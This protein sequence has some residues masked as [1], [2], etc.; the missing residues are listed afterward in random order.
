MSRSQFATVGHIVKAHGLHGEVSFAPAKGLSV[1]SLQGLE[2]WITP[3][4]DAGAKTR[5]RSLRQGPKGPLVGLEGFDT[6]EQAATLTGR[7]LLALV[8]ALPQE[9]LDETVDPVGAS[10]VD[11]TRGDL[12]V[13]TG[14]IETGANDVWVVEG[15]K[16]G[17]V[18]IPVIDTVVI[19]HDVENSR[20]TVRLLPG[21]IDEEG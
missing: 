15:E 1:D 20:V 12:G 4:P 19:E 14:V 10:V 5:I 9:W 18:L 17:E 21:L 3:P 7:N 13:I 6:L 8:D 16:Y 11:E 2:V